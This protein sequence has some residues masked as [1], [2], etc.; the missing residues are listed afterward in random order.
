M[1]RRRS[2][3]VQSEESGETCFGSVLAGF[4]MF[5]LDFGYF[6]LA[7]QVFWLR[8]WVGFADFHAFGFASAV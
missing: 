6:L 4:R 2:T 3:A 8:F 5:W 1:G 7:F